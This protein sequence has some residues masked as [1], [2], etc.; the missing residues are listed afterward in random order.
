[1]SELENDFI[2][3]EL[4]K[5]K[6]VNLTPAHAKLYSHYTKVNLNQEGIQSWNEK[7]FYKRFSEAIL[8]IDAGLTAKEEGLTEWKSFFKS[9]GE[10][11][12]WLSHP[13]IN[14]ID[15][16]LEILAAGLYQLAGY[17]ALA[18]GLFRKS[19]R[20][21]YANVIIN[22]LEGNYVELYKNLSEYWYLNER[23]SLSL[24]DLSNSIELTIYDQ[25]MKGIGVFYEYSRWGNNERIDLA[26]RKLKSI[27]NVMQHSKDNFSWLLARIIAEVV[28]ETYLSSMR[29]NLLPIIDQLPK[30]NRVFLENYIRFNFINNKS[31]LWESQKDGIEKLITGKDFAL[32]TPTGSGKTTIAEIAIIKEM[33]NDKV[34]FSQR[35]KIVVYLVPSRALAIEV[36]LKLK[37]TLEKVNENINVTGLYGGLDWGPND[38]WVTSNDPTLLICTYEKGEALI[39]YLG[40]VFLNRVELVIIDEAHAIQFTDNNLE[41]LMKGENR[42]YRLE[43]LTNRLF[44]YLEGKKIIAL[45]AVANGNKT[46]SNWVANNDTDNEETL[47]ES[48]YRSTR[49]LVGRLLWSDDGGYRIYYDL[50]NGK[51]MN[52]NDDGNDVPYILNPFTKFPTDF[53]KIPKK[54]SKESVGKRQ[55]LHLFWSAM[56]MANFDSQQSNSVLISI[57]QHINGY[58]NDF[59]YFIKTFLKKHKVNY[60]FE[61][62][63]NETEVKMYEKALELYLDYYGEESVEYQLLKL[64]IIVHH[65]NIPSLLSKQLIK[66]IEKK[67]ILVVLATSTLTE[68]VNLPFEIIIVPTLIRNRDSLSISEVKNLIGRAGRPG[69]ST[70]GRTFIFLEKVPKDSSSKEALKN[71]NETVE[72][73]TE[74]KNKPLTTVESPLE[75]LMKYIYLKWSEISKV[76]SQQKFLSWLETTLPKKCISD[77]E[78]IELGMALDNFDEYLLSIIVEK[79]ILDKDNYMNIVDLEEYLIEIWNKSYARFTFNHQEEWKDMFVNRGKAIPTNIYTDPIVRRRVYKTSV[80]PINAEEILS[81]YDEIVQHLHLGYDYFKWDAENKTN[82]L[83]ELIDFF[84]VLNKFEFPEKVNRSKDDWKDILN[85]W[86]NHNNLF[87]NLNK[88]NISSYIKFIK[89]NLDYKFNWGLGT[90]ISLKLDDVNNGEIK[91][92]NFKEWKKTNL[93]WIVYWIKDLITWGSL[94]PVATALLASGSEYLRAKAELRAKEYYLENEDLNEDEIYNPENIGKWIKK[95]KT[96]YTY[97][98]RKLEEFD[99]ELLRDF[100]DVRKQEW[101]VI[102]LIHDE[103]TYW[104]DMTGYKLAKSTGN[105]RGLIELNGKL[106][107]VLDSKKSSIKIRVY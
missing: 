81:K 14:L 66:L 91:E 101:N 90:I 16:P 6:K 27:S 106:E 54:F 88:N 103:V 24:E 75:V 100:N 93:P 35:G 79:E 7:D 25:L 55:R 19:Y 64:G 45:S 61:S 9:S 104:V 42:S 3:I 96:S 99:V 21:E 87:S 76:K 69:V 97:D 71:Y 95:I 33:F 89:K 83:T 11:L 56:Q 1:M 68:G 52:F 49:Q 17:P 51:K 67:V 38:V 105:Y 50:M 63:I 22:L 18:K 53:D 43:L 57:T 36:E 80:S 13:K 20:S 48:N 41:N 82:F 74:E 12:E 8:L 72:A 28:E 65:A 15:E 40:T 2:Q 70:E 102:P 98:I 10:L 46:L 31:I 23:S 107:Y 30:E 86:L 62:P 92:L 32:C 85:W 26:T 47:V 29:T 34:D 44:Y 94:D 59:L 58:A 39:R 77:D 37:K 84:R 78:Q 60:K 4:N 5:I 73:L